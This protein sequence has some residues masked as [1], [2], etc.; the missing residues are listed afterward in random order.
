MFDDIKQGYTGGSVDVFKPYG[1]NI[2]CYDVNSLYPY[3]MKEYPMP[4]GNPIYFDGDISKIENKPFGIF[5][6]EIEAPNNIDIPIL[7]LRTKKN[8]KQTRTL[9]PL[10]KWRGVYTSE[11]LYNAENYG[12]KFKIINGYLFKKDYIFKEYVDELYAIKENSNKNSTDYLIAKLL[13]NSLYGRLGM[14]PQMETNLIILNDE[15]NYY[16]KKYEI[17]N[18]IDLKNGKELVT[19]LNPT[20][21]IDNIPLNISIPIATM[22]TAY[23]R[24]HM[25]KFKNI[26]DLKILYTDTD[27]I[28]F[29]KPLD[30]KIIGKE[31]GKMKLENIFKEFVCISPKVYGGITD[32]NEYIKIKGVKNPINFYQLKALLYKNTKLEIKQDKWYKNITDGNIFIKNEI[33]TLMITDN[34]RNNIYDQNGKFIDTKPIIL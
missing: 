18:V 22:V 14:N 2:Y 26:E 1:E 17:S 28:F 15:S 25:T 20:K 4:V 5:F 29:N 12:Y 31:L 30:S 7:Q 3:V 34:K 13:L 10:G 9:S 21:D 6:V 11:E 16:I 24:I 27:S 19:F 23:A 8:N 32:N 33:Y